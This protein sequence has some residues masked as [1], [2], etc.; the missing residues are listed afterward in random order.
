MDLTREQPAAALSDSDLALID[1]LQR[2]PRAPWAE[3]GRAI[4]VSAPTARRRWEHLESEGTAWI[5]TYAG[6]T[7]G[8]VAALVQVRCR[9]GT[10]DA[11]AAVVQRHP[12]IVTVS[13]QT[14]ERDLGLIVFASDLP[15]LRCI[16]QRDLGGNEDVLGVRSSI[17]T[18]VFRDGSH[19]RAGALD[20]TDRS[21]ATRGLTGAAPRPTEAAMLAILGALERDGR[22]PTATI[23]SALGTG[24]AH[25][26]RTLQRLLESRRIVQ[27]IDVTLD[28]PHW[29]HS[30]A[31]WMVVPA[32][33]LEDAARRIGEL[34]ETRLCAALAGGSSNLYVIAWL[35][36]LQD[37][38]DVEA[39]IVRDLPARV[40][41]R[42]L[43]LHYYKRLG[44]VFD[45]ARRRVGQVP[46]VAADD[47]DAALER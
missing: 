27:R 16:L 46:W 9:P 42:S 6:M 17:M 32:S 20:P 47:R 7:D 38:A 28:Q 45:D 13:A 21:P 29:P 26:R 41:D 4:G 37:A 22:A 31:L 33:Q 25:A 44:H 18:R 40:I 35:R 30:L 11:V 3:V 10:S 43:V 15:G 5:T 2:D 19:W 23:A 39:A 34:P 14:G 12:R 8:L 36:D 24:D 1:A